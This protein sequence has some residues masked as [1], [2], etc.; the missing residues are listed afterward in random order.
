M[1]TTSSTTSSQSSHDALGASLTEGLATKEVR[2]HEHARHRIKER[3]EH[4]LAIVMKA[5]GLKVARGTRLGRKPSMERW[6]RD[7]AEVTHPALSVPALDSVAAPR[8]VTGPFTGLTLG[9]L[10]SKPRRHKAKK[11]DFEVIPPIRAVIALDDF[12]H[13]LE[14]DEPWEYISGACLNDASTWKA[15]SYAQVAAPAM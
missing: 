12:G 9:D 14:A 13:D 7:E 3:R 5:W 10:I 6:D 15:L 4:T 1:S 8:K 11:L 2:A